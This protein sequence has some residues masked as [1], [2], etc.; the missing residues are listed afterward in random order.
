SANG[1][2]SKTFPV[3]IVDQ[4]ATILDVQ[5]YN[6]KLITN[7][8]ADSTLLAVDQTVNYTDQS[9]GNPTSWKWTFDGGTPS[10]SVE[11]NP[12][13]SYQQPGKYSVKLVVTHTGAADSLV[14]TDYIEVKPWY[15]M[16]NKAYS[17][18]DAQFFDTGGPNTNYTGNENSVITFT[19][20]EPTRK[21][22]AVFNS[23]DIEEGGANCSNDKLLIFDGSSIGSN[24]L[25]TVCGSSNPSN[26]VATNPSGALTFQFISNSTISKSG[27]DITL[28][29][30]SNVGISE[31]VQNLI[32]VYPNPVINGSTVVETNDL[33]QMLVIKDV[34]GRNV[35]S[36]LPNA[37]RIVVDCTWPSGIY[38]LHLQIN[39]RWA[40][41]KLQVIKR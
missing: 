26:V 13:V 19:P 2:L 7:F 3:Q 22:T 32:R 20:T 28:T 35:Y 24:L 21:L 27:W 6:G 31:N 16:A 41:K 37:K 30:D 15:I 25:A 14:R 38:I 10:F 40:S 9:A 12:V 29:C 36:S 4:Q 8:I 1:Y 5:L 11:K 34:T 18:C 39:G 33:V 17:V 23:L